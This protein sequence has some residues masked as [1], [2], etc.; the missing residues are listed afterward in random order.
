MNSLLNFAY[1]KL[2][3]QL[4]GNCENGN[5]GKSERILSVISGGF[6]LGMGLKNVLRSPLTSMSGIG[7]GGMLIYRGVTGNCPVK[8][9]L[10]G[11]QP[12]TTVIEHRYFVK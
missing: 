7:L 3:T 9:A 10:E 12:E 8:E 4:E 6:I 1:N 5:V 11:K 2:K